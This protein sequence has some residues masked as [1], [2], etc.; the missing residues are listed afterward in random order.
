MLYQDDAVSL[1][2]PRFYQE[3]LLPAEH[4]VLAHFDR[5]MIHIHSGALPI[6][7]DSLLAL[8][9]LDAIE[10]LLDPTG[11]QLP[12][13]I[14]CFKRILQHKALL[15]CGEM[16]LEQMQWLMRELPSAGWC[17]LPKADTESQAD[18]L[19]SRLVTYAQG[20]QQSAIPACLHD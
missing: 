20:L 11:K 5:T 7:L 19:Y 17:L 1:L 13:L 14:D 15:I 3:Y 6:M 18:V 16:G 4:A 9:S 8:D 10:V 12:E 2:S